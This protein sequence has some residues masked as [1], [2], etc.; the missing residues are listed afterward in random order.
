VKKGEPVLV[1]GHFL[2]IWRKQADGGWR[3]EADIGVPHAA[4]KQPIAPFSPREVLPAASNPALKGAEALP[5]LRQKEAELSLA[6]AGKGGLALVPELAKGAR[7]LRPRSLPLREATE[8]R[9]ALEVELP[10]S[11]RE[12]SLVQV[13]ASGDLGW[14]CGES[15]PDKLGATA[16]FL[17]IWILESGAW[18]VLFDVRLPHPAAPK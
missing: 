11:P 6:W 12:P 15:G 3:V 4:P 16:S 9:Q 1:N 18:M 17:R 8:I 13:A 2:S 10:G 14:A 7:V 5:A